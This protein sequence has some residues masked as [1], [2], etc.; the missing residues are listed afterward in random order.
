[1][2]FDKRYEEPRI[3]GDQI[4]NNTAET[5]EEQT[6]VD[7]AVDAVAVDVARM[8]ESLQRKKRI[9][10]KTMPQQPEP[11][12]PGVRDILVIKINAEKAQG[13]PNTERDSGCCSSRDVGFYF[14]SRQ[15]WRI[16]WPRI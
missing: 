12:P 13:P 14:L 1:M 8:M 4:T 9:E 5:K 11:E 16:S 3:P 15:I 10:A 6:A 2:F 7:T